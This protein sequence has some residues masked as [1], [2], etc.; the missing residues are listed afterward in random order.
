MPKIHK[1]YCYVDETGQDTKG[2]LFIV[3]AGERVKLNQY[4]EEVENKCGIGKRKW[5]RAKSVSTS[6]DRYLES[7][8]TGDLK[9]KIFYRRY[10]NSG[11]GV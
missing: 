10:A 5:V 3:V 7:L 9:H 11:S 2:R 1:L 6:R 8:N 4:L